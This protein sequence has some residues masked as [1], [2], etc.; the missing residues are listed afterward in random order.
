MGGTMN[1]MIMFLMCLSICF[2]LNAKRSLLRSFTDKTGKQIDERYVPDTPVHLRNPGPVVQ[3]NRSSV[4]LNEVPAFDWCYGCSATSAAMMAGYYDRQ[5]Y[6]NA[7]AGPANGG[8]CPLTNSVWGAGESPLSA[9]HQGYDGLATAGHVNRFWVASGN[10][11]NDPYGSGNPQSTYANCTADYM[12][13]NQDYWNNEDGGTTFYSYTD[14]SPLY[15]YSACESENPRKR[16]GIRGLR[17]FFESRGYSV[18]TNYNQYIQGYDGNS[19]GYTLAN[20]QTSI[21][22]GI[23]VLIQIAGHT[24]LGIGY[25]SGTSTIYVHDTWDYQMHSMTWGGSY[26]GMQHYGVAVIQLVSLYSTITWNPGSFSQSLE[27]NQ[28]ASQS[29]VIGNSGSAALT[30][31]CSL[32][33]PG[34]V[35]SESFSSSTIPSGWTQQHVS[36]LSTNWTFMSGGINGHPSAA[37]DGAYNA[38]LYNPSTSPSVERLITPQMNLAGASSASLSFWHAQES[39]YGD[40]DELRVYYRT[41][42]SGTWNLLAT[43]TSSLTAWTQRTLSLPSISSTY[44]LAF[45]GTAKYGYGACLDKIVVSKTIS[46]TNWLTLNG[47]SSAT[48]SINPG[49]ASQSVSLGFNSAGLNPGIYYK[50][51]Y[52]TSNS[53][54]NSDLEITVSLTVLQPLGIPQ[55][56]SVVQNSGTGAVTLSWTASSGSPTGYKIS[57]CPLPDF[58][59]GVVALGTVSAP[60]T[61]YVDSAAATRTKGFYRVQAYRN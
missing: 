24:M 47:G 46:T 14:G 54:T 8:V 26:S 7:Y 51:I 45:E 59:S 1:R 5:Y 13:T 38:V 2:G 39:W 55:N 53:S 61:S 60:Q 21:N 36:G 43:Y 27:S 42:A 25:E 28:S 56:P 22:S 23:P 4:V 31:T 17:L 58:S 6:P 33:N 9:T 35:L 41:S 3:R 37:Y 40:Q 48:G 44:Y 11:G 34:S 52:L 16:D 20:Y 12:G 15:N 30:Y 32:P 50:T 57:Y 49:A 29:L 10:S 19:Q 18:T